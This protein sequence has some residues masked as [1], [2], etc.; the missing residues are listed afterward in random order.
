MCRPRVSVQYLESVRSHSQQS[1]SEVAIRAYVL[2]MRNKRT[3]FLYLLVG[4]IVGNFT[5]ALPAGRI[6][7]GTTFCSTRQDCCFQYS[8][9]EKAFH[10]VEGAAGCVVSVGHA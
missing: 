1:Q 6:V 3:L 2:A 5:G 10:A 4:V 7:R 8:K 9:V